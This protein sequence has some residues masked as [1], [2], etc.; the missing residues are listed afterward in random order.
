MSIPLS[1][2]LACRNDFPVVDVRS[3]NEFEQGHIPNAINIPLLKNEERVAVGTDY[4]QKGADIAIKTGL[5][6]VGPRLV[7]LV[8]EAERVAAGRELLVH[9]WR[10]GMRSAYFCQFVGMARVKATPLAGG[11]KAYRQLVADTFQQPFRLITVGGCTGSGKTALLQQLAE[12]G[13]QVIDLEALAHHKGSV[14]GGLMQSPQPTTEQFQN[15][16]FERLLTLDLSKPVWVEDESI[17]IGKIFL[18]DALW[19]QMSQSPVVEVVLNKQ[20]RTD[21]LVNEYGAA[22]PEEFIAAIQKISKRL[23]GL[24][25]Q[26]A[27]EFVRAG[28]MHNAI[29]VLLTYYDR[30]YEFGLEKK[31]AAGRVRQRVEWNGRDYA[32]VVQQ[33]QDF[34][35]HLGTARAQ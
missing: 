15:N 7:E 16:L 21:R 25:Q 26:Q 24:A 11:Y 17:T 34:S 2:F 9:C 35:T 28:Q 19:R 23:G 20:Q 6:L 14:F 13:E 8:S 12:R 29:D 4:K 27:I 1:E 5:R 10:G 22:N 3:E 32:S 30:A 33:L 31:M 18:P